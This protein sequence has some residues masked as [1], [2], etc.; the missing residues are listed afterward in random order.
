[1]EGRYGFYASC[2]QSS[3]SKW[4]RKY[5]TEWIISKK[6]QKKKLSSGK[7]IKVK[8]LITLPSWSTRYKP[9]HKLFICSITCSLH[10]GIHSIYISVSYYFKARQ[11]DKN[12]NEEENNPIRSH[13]S[14]LLSSRGKGENPNEKTSPLTLYSQPGRLPP[15]PRPPPPPPLPPLLPPASLTTS[16]IISFARSTPSF[17][18]LISIASPC[19]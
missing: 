1:M 15:L 8:R 4:L 13:K 18:P 14:S 2:K 9:K 10:A 5:I 7:R 16:K 12:R 6:H 11:K 19:A 3:T 17:S